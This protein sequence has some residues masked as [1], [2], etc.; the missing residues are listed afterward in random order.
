VGNHVEVTQSQTKRPAANTLENWITIGPNGSPNKVKEGDDTSDDKEKKKKG[1]AKQS[2]H[3]KTKVLGETNVENDKRKKGKS[4]KHPINTYKP[5]E[6]QTEKSKDIE[7]SSTAKSEDD[8]TLPQRKLDYGINTKNNKNSDNHTDKTDKGIVIGKDK[9]QT[10]LNFKSAVTAGSFA[11]QEHT[12]RLRISCS[13]QQ[14]GVGP[15]EKGQEIKRVL[16]A[17]ALDL[18]EVD[19]DASILPWK[20]TDDGCMLF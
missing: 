10:S 14:G 3:L 8:K 11:I 19:K 15:L 20:E 5:I 7:K 2:P 13:G 1:K 4:K 18:K 17:I 12:V 6:N 9:N 16:K